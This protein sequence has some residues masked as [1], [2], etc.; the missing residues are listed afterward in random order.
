MRVL[1]LPKPQ[2]AQLSI[3]VTRSLNFPDSEVKMAGN[4]VDAA[5]GAYLK[6]TKEEKGEFSAVLRGY[7]M[8]KSGQSDAGK[9]AAAPRKAG[10]SPKAA[11]AGTGGSNAA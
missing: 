11:A 6:L 2:G 1:H 3:R 9:K 8:A 10:A 4:A 5:I 7:E